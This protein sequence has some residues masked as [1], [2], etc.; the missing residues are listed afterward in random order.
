M[1]MSETTP[2]AARADQATT[3]LATELQRAVARIYRRVR[4]EMPASQLGGTQLSVLT[5]LVKHGPQTLRAL[6]DRERVTPPAMNQTVNALQAVDLVVRR[7]DPGDGRKVLV[8]A[9][10]RGAELVAEGRRVKHAWLNTRL[11][12]L[13]DAER[14]SLIEAARLFNEMADS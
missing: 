11:E 12:Q 10:E 3:D 7:P 13:T 2:G 8:T 6:S 5:Y 9:T 4:S 14:R 1:T